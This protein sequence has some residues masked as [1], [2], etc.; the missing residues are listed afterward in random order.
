MHMIVYQEIHTINS[1]ILQQIE[2][3]TFS[4]NWL[5]YLDMSDAFDAAAPIAPTNDERLFF[6]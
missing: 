4:W 1:D 2:Y 5:S 6:L 3:A